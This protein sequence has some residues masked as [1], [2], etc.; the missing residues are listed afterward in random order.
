MRLSEQVLTTDPPPL[1]PFMT[2]A[3]KLQMEGRKIAVLAQAVVDYCPPERFSEA[4]RQAL[5]D[6]EPGLH[7][8]SPDA[9][10][11]DLRHGLAEYLV[12]NFGITADPVS[13]LIVTPG[14]NMAAYQALGAI[15][16]PGDEALLIAPWYFNH[17]M[18]ITLLGAKVRQVTAAAA[19]RFIPTVEA[20][21]E[22][23]SPDLRV[24]VLVNP[25]NPTGAVYPAEWIRSLAAAMVADPRW[26]DVWLL[27]DQTYQEIYFT[28]ERPLS[29]ASLPALRE[30]TITVGSFSKSLALAGWR[31]GFL[32]G[33]PALI[34]EVMKIQDSSV[35][36]AANPAQQALAA[37]L[38]HRDELVDYFQDK[39][40][41][42]A[43]RRD[44]LLSPLLSAPGWRIEIPAGAC[45]AFATLPE[46]LTAE[47]FAWRLLEEGGVAVVPGHHF[48]PGGERSIRLSFGAGTEEELA[49][50]GRRIREFTKEAL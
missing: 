29:L 32:H 47:A 16:A 23:W 3:K 12:D 44:A 7:L 41:V 22:A 18:T 27:A 42:L 50:A 33:P 36:C 11:A 49:E 8:Y 46:P 9:G 37:T 24:L 38:R 35:I 28:D 5:A 20:I 31:L 14:A 19:N 26:R 39:R 10:R 30:R 6:N 4:L 34:E 25:N 21:L 40:L 13:E 2:R 15:L 45:F 1:S 48:G 43:K 17:E